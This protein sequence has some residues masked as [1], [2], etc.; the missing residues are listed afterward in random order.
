MENIPVYCKFAAEE[1][2]DRDSDIET[3]KKKLMLS[4]DIFKSYEQKW[5]DT[6]D[7]TKMNNWLSGIY[8][9]RIDGGM[10]GVKSIDDWIERLGTLGIN[11]VYSSG[12]S[13]SFS[14]VPRN[15]EDWELSQ[16]ANISYLAPLLWHRMTGNSSPNQFLLAALQFMPTGSL[17]NIASKMLSDYDAAFLGFRN[18]RMGNQV[19]IGELIPIFHDHYFLYDF[20]MTGTALRC[21]RRG[22]ATDDER[23]MTETLRRKLIG[24]R[25]E[26]YLK[27]L[28]NIDRS[29]SKGQKILIFGAPYQFKELCDIASANNRKLRLKEGSIALIGGGWKS[30]TGEAINR[31]ALVN[32]VTDTLALKPEMI[33]EGY[34]MTETSALTLRCEHGR[35][36]IPPVIEPVIFDNALNPLEGDDISGAFGFMDTLASSHPGFIISN[37]FVR[38][39][40]SDC[41]CGL[42]GPSLL[43]IGRM[44]GSEVKGC[45]GIMGS[46]PA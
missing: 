20:D 26:N 33:L 7:Y 12:T 38:M 34:S 27:L 46:F 41:K 17:V 32:M 1:G 25:E 23:D 4:S 15:D 31:D 44:P 42:C 8:H 39:V 21:L 14:F 11:V 3:I 6:N 35:F 18:G 30:F 13:G 37:D 29:I 43:E 40:T 24:Q 10:S 22:A 16:T 28:E 9:K 45:G 19:L 5:L 36:H 2:C